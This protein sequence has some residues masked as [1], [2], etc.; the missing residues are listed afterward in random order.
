LIALNLDAA[1]FDGPAA[2]ARTAHFFAELFFFRQPDADET[3]DHGDG[4]A[5]AAAGLAS[6]L[7]AAAIFLGLARGCRRRRADRDGSHRRMRQTG[8]TQ[9][10]KGILRQRPAAIRRYFITA[11]H[12]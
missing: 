2:T 9:R 3:V 12:D 8:T 7:D 4:L 11:R 6:H 1:F 5:A 10:R